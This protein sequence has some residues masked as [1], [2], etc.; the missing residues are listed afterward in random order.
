MVDVDTA[1]SVGAG[2]D[3]CP[4]WPGAALATAAERTAAASTDPAVRKRVVR[5]MRSIPRSRVA[6]ED[7]ES[8]IGNDG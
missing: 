3:E 7:I 6:R 1:G 4:E 8:S 5:P 2:V